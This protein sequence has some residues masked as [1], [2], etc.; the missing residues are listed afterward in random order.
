MCAKICQVEHGSP[1]HKARIKA[2]E[3]LF[4]INGHSIADVLDYKFYSYDSVL[5]IKVGDRNVRVKKQEGEDLGL[6]FESYLMDKAKRC[7][8]KC[9]FCFIDQLPEGMRETLYF[10]DDD[11]RM[12]F[13]MGNYI[14]LTNLSEQDIERMIR[15]RIS[16]INVSVHATDPQVRQKM[17]G[18]PRAGECMNILKRFAQANITLNCQIVACPGVNDGEVLKKSLEDL[19]SLAP[20]VGSISVVPVGLTRFRE[21]LYPLKPVDKKTACEIID[22][23]DEVGASCVLKHG[24]RIVF[25]GDELYI[26]AGRNIPGTE[27]YEDYPQLENGVGLIALMQEEFAFALEDVSGDEIIAPFTMATGVSAAPFIAKLID[28]LAKKCNNVFKWQ[29]VPVKNRFFGETIDVAGLVTGKDLIHELAG[30]E[31]GERLFIPEVMLRHGTHVFLDDVSV[32]QAERELGVP[33]IPV[34]NDGGVLLD[35][36]LGV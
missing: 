3:E 6:V 15:M 8:N 20:A 4:S 30:K 13:L 32:E 10:K 17:L 27:Y 33:I 26:K 5:N 35:S 31:L 22:I 34:M 16:P 24:S 19:V 18:N 25:C 2:G 12:S 7:A 21:K 11:A 9:I 28:D 23:V 1:A 14:S 36:I 29:V